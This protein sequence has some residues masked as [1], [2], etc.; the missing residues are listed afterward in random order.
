MHYAA[1]WLYLSSPSHFC[2]ISCGTNV[3]QIQLRLM[4]GYHKYDNLYLIAKTEATGLKFVERNVYK[5]WFGCWW[6]L[7]Q[8]KTKISGLNIWKLMAY[9]FQ[10]P[11][12]TRT[13]TMVS[14]RKS[15][16]AVLQQSH[17]H[18]VLWQ[19][20]CSEWCR[21][22]CTGVKDMDTG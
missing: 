10:S 12:R 13:G 6:M 4:A 14:R 15:F 21:H 8:E 3:D 11:F 19:C 2:F 17:R 5:L 7:E 20:N 9:L 22:T 16:P 18:L 1:S